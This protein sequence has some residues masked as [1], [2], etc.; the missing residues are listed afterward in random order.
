MNGTT[1]SFNMQVLSE[2]FKKIE[3]SAFSIKGLVSGGNCTKTILNSMKT[4]NKLDSKIGKK[5]YCTFCSRYTNGRYAFVTIKHEGSTITSLILGLKS[6]LPVYNTLSNQVEEV[7]VEEIMEHMPRYKVLYS[8]ETFIIYIP[9]ES[10]QVLSPSNWEEYY[11]VDNN[12]DI[13]Y[14]L[15]C[16]IAIKPEYNEEI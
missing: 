10:I 5:D 13:Y 7:T 16:G 6:V 3:D 8:K 14:I 15:D 2:P 11:F 1:F 12:K 4:Y 9:I